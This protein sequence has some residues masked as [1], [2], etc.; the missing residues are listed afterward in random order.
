MRSI[1]YVKINST[2]PSFFLSPKPN[3]D[4]F[5]RVGT[6]SERRQRHIKGG[7]VI[8]GNKTAII[9]YGMVLILATFV[10]TIWKQT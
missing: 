9:N 6:V 5:G 2:V 7:W 4:L 10:H 3:I 8:L 1:K